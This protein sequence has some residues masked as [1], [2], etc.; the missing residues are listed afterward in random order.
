MS[1]KLPEVT[2]EEWKKIQQFNREITEEF[3]QQQ[4][5]SP[6][7]LKQYTSGLKHFF[8]WVKDYRNNKQ[9][10]DLKPR[11][12]LAY[13]N[14]LISSG[15]SSNAV[16]FKR[17]VVSSL[18]GYIEIYYSD[19]FPMFRNI[20]NKKIPNPSNNLVYDKQP[21]NKE[22]YNLLIKEL[23]KRKEYQMLAYIK[24]TYTSG[25]RKSEAIQLLKEV[26]D[27]N[28]VKNKNYY[29]THNIRC[30]GKGKEGEIRKLVFDD[31]VLK[32]FKKWLDY[33]GE[34]DCSYMFVSKN[35]NGFT[36][37]VGETTFNYWC[38]NIF[39]NIVGRRVHPHMIRSTR[40]THLVVEE[41][42]NIESAQALL[43]HKNSDTTNLYVIKD[44]NEE[45]DDIF[46]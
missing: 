26:V 23:E 29:L 24:F 7:T 46:E 32:S 39:S 5:L 22:E 31:Y 17:S 30:K 20:Y 9:I 6:Y 37:Q 45:I 12:A 41:N 40:A 16:K 18:C 42:K 35:K 11:D 38:S 14:F 4:H 21:L 3:L 36:K 8:K 44:I 13:Q 33:R 28:K 2:Q 27:Y 34:D 19:E 1:Y 43:G 10:T 15:L 25:C